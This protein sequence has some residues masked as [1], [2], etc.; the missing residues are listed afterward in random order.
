M[1]SKRRVT[2]TDVAKAADVSPG[3]VSRV[4]N[5]RTS[6]SKISKE[7]QKQVLEV[8]EQLGYRPNLFAS[9]LRTHRTGVIGAVVRDINDP[10][11]IL[12]TQELQKTAQSQEI[13]LFLSCANYDPEIARRQLNVMS[14]WFDGL[15]M[16]G[17]MLDRLAAISSLNV[18]NMLITEWT[19]SS[20]NSKPLVRINDARGTIL[21]L[22]YLYTLGHRRI[23]FI[24]NIEYA[25]IRERLATFRQ[26]VEERSLYWVDAYLQPCPNIREAAITCTH[27]LLNLP[28]PPTAIF[29]MSD[30]LALGSMSGARQMDWR[31]PGTIS[32]I[33]F[34][35][36][37]ESA[38]A[39]PCLTT[40]RQPVRDMAIKSFDLLM[41]SIDGTLMEDFPLPII[42][43]PKL[44]V[45]NSCSPPL[46]KCAEE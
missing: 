10:F 46:N 31:V 33:G 43:E 6:N 23:A 25:G 32:I 39:F 22:D 4:L 38:A 34:D 16:I 29:C 12:I 41:E 9:A 7:T 20:K 24:G 35:D 36:I 13:E 5:H 42:V 45:R 27:N 44:I 18:Q 37:K 21:G 3:T 11:L 2:I 14:N 17:D 8:V 19:E 15:L 1:K 28:N 26:Y 40:I 30:L